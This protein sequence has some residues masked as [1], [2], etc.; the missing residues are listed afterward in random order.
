MLK[1][2]LQVRCYLSKTRIDLTFLIEGQ[3]NK[4]HLGPHFWTLF[5]L[6]TSADQSSLAYFVTSNGQFCENF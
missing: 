1:N 6:I 4:C 5:I 2:C 3:I